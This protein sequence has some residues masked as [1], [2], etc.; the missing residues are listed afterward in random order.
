LTSS[1]NPTQI[2]G[3]LQESGVSFDGIDDYMNLGRGFT[4]DSS[5]DFSD[6]TENYTISIWSNPVTGNTGVVFGG[7]NSSGGANRWYIYHLEGSIEFNFGLDETTRVVSGD[8]T[9]WHHIVIKRAYNSNVALYIDGVCVYFD[10]LTSNNVTKTPSIGASQDDSS[11][12]VYANIRVADI[13][14][15]DQYL[16]S[17]NV[18]SLFNQRCEEFGFTQIDFWGKP[19]DYFIHE[20]TM[21]NY[22]GDTIFDEKNNFNLTKVGGTFTTHN[23]VNCLY[24]NG[25]SDYFLLGDVLSLYTTIGWSLSF[26]IY[27]NE[28]DSS[29]FII[30][31][32]DLDGTNDHR[33]YFKAY[34]SGIEANVAVEITNET[35]SVTNDGWFHVVITKDDDN[36]WKVYRD[37]VEIISNS[38]GLTPTLEITPAFGAL[39][40][41]D[42]SDIINQFAEFYLADLKVYYEAITSS[43]ISDLYNSEVGKYYLYK[44]DFETPLVGWDRTPYVP[45]ISTNYFHSGTSSLLFNQGI[46]GT[47]VYY[48]NTLVSEIDISTGGIVA[49]LWFYVGG[50]DSDDFTI[51]FDVKDD[52]DAPSAYI[53]NIERE[54]TSSVHMFCPTTSKTP[55][56]A[57]TINYIASNGKWFKF[58][59]EFNGVGNTDYCRLYDTD[60][61]TLLG[62]ISAVN[63]QYTRLTGITVN[64]AINQ[65]GW[66]V[67][68]DDINIFRS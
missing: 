48:G 36:T 33:V 29:G 18:V 31:G 37:G 25:T 57:G 4:L 38:G 67:Y 53:I 46:N 22:S 56:G 7:Y 60:G 51:G 63:A 39:R 15:F 47:S 43:Q 20:Y 45:V 35:Y 19:N 10:S 3:N 68:V 6:T 52:V 59:V 24:F 27:T 55:N 41:Q 12:G 8:F 44:E 34:D 62:T 64:D 66:T 26:W 65:N 40:N 5:T 49:S 58:V 42:V 1:G 17:E 54:L 23:G 9:G 21:N 2:A 61:T 14:I 32:H 16:T 30:G 28:T 13:Q 50:R 11:H